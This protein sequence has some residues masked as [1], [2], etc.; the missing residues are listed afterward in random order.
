MLLATYGWLVG[1]IR[2]LP[3]DEVY[4]ICVS[5]LEAAL[6]ADAERGGWRPI[7]TAPKVEKG[8][9]LDLWLE[10]LNYNPLISGFRLIEC[11]W[12]ED[13]EWVDA[14]DELID[15]QVWRITHWRLSPPALEG[16]GDG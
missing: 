7:E 11:T 16:A 2:D 3:L 4:K 1:D 14:H 10:P 5:N 13:R 12:Q 8:P 6:A 15:E 9:P